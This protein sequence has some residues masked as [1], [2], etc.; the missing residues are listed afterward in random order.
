LL[1]NAGKFRV[2]YDSIRIKSPYARRQVLDRLFASH[3]SPKIQ[4]RLN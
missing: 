3:Y 4:N 2:L 1:I